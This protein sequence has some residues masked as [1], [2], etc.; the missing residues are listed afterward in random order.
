VIEGAQDSGSLITARHAA[1][2]GR[3]VFAVPGPITSPNSA[4]P[5]LLIK[6]GAKLVSRVDDI[7]E[8]LNIRT[9]NIVHSAKEIKPENPEEERILMVMKDGA[10]HIDEIVRETGLNV[11]QVM[12]L[13]TMM[14]IK[15]MVKNLG[16]M[17]YGI[18]R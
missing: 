3:E 14:E 2:Q 10:K 9:K 7:L 5:F 6:E 15:G 8:E 16:K 12:S 13:I 1:D 11:G 4:G 18:N 17:M